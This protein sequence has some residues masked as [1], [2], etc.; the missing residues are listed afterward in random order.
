MDESEFVIVFNPKSVQC[1]H[2]TAADITEQLE[3]EGWSVEVT[4]I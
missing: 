1:I 4:A 3:F 2:K